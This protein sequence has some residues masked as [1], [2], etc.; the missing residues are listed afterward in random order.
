VQNYYYKIFDTSRQDAFRLYKDQSAVIWNGTMY[1]G[2]QNLNE[3]FKVLPSTQHHVHSMDAQP[4]PVLGTNASLLRDVAMTPASASNILVTV[5]GTVSY[6]GA[7][8]RQFHQTFVLA[9]DLGGPST[10]LYVSLDC[11]RLTA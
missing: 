5:I 11:F 10:H 8:P 3:F 7:A 9:Q 1:R 4:I 6:G 2:L